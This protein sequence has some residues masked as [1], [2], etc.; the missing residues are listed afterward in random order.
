MSNPHRYHWEQLGTLRFAQPPMLFT[1]LYT[2]LLSRRLFQDDPSVQ[3]LNGSVVG[4]PHGAGE[5]DELAVRGADRVLYEDKGNGRA[6]CELHVVWVRGSGAGPG[7]ICRAGCAASKRNGSTVHES[8][9]VL[10]WKKRC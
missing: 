2:F 4:M 6:R 9:T 1:P 5:F 3:R 8:I 7:R 10:P